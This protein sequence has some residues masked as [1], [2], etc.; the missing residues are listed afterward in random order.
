MI[1]DVR[2][3]TLDTGLWTLGISFFTY[4][5][6]MAISLLLNPTLY[7]LRDVRVLTGGVAFQG[8]FVEKAS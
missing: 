5:L 8:H 1:F 2:H 4:S 3:W 6:K 7:G